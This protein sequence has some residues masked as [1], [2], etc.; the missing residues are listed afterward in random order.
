[1]RL[2]GFEDGQKNRNAGTEPQAVFERWIETDPEDDRAFEA[3]PYLREEIDGVERS[4][5]P[6]N[7][8]LRFLLGDCNEFGQVGTNLIVKPFSDE[9]EKSLMSRCDVQTR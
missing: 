9:A 4:Y 3:R 1:V 6:I 2:N 7:S 8:I 5:F